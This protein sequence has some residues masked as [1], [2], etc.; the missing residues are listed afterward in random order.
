VIFRIPS[1]RKKR[2]GAVQRHDGPDLLRW[3][4]AVHQIPHAH[5]VVGRAGEGEDPIDFQ[6][7]AMQNFEQQRNSFQ[8]AKTFFDALPLLLADDIAALPR[9]APINGAAASSPKVLRH[10]RGHPQ[11]PALAHKIRGIEALVAAHRH[12][13]DTRKFLQHVQLRRARGFPHPAVRN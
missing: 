11:V 3:N 2:F 1:A 5:Q 10:V 12:P 4:Y 8:P 7:S 6:R 9:G 13:P